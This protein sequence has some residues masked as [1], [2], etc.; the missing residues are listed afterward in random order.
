MPDEIDML[1]DAEFENQ[2]A[3]MGED[4]IA[5]TK[6]VARNQYQSSKVV[7][8]NVKRIRRL[9]KQNKKV[10]GIVGG[11]GAI[12]ATAITASI[13]YLLRRGA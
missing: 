6:F 3:E 12:L 11:A 2:M 10:F 1:E 8:S 9:E 13:D 4:P 5:L 7:N